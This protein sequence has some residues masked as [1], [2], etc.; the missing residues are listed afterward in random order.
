MRPGELLWTA[1]TEYRGLD[2]AAPDV[3]V[4]SGLAPVVADTRLV[5]RVLHN[6]IGNAY[7]HGGDRRAR[8]G[9][10]RGGGSGVR[11][12]V[13]DDG[14]GIPEGERERVFE[15][16]I[17]G[18]GAARGSGLGLAFCKLVIEQLGGRIWA[19]GSPLGGTRIAFE[20]PPAP[21]EVPARAHLGGSQRS[22]VSR[23]LT[24]E[25]RELLTTAC[26]DLSRIRLLARILRLQR[27]TP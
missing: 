6:L 17:Q 22:G 21:T 9:G 8:G 19:D 27:D 14:P 12:A 1:V 18:S 10:G 2:R 5:G 7:K 3:R 13:D 16:F 4:A 24:D 23:R 15:R 11:F 26:G 20:L 25:P